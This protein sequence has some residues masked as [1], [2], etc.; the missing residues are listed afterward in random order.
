MWLFLSSID[1]KAPPHILP[2]RYDS[3]KEC[4]RKVTSRNGSKK[5]E[6]TATGS[7]NNA[8]SVFARCMA[9]CRSG[10]KYQPSHLP[11]SGS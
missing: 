8:E 5:P 1:N 11:A 10:E 7:L 3:S 6:R 2:F 9:G 4:T